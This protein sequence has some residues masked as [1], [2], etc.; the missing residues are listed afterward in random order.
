MEGRPVVGTD[1]PVEGLIVS[2]TSI[3]QLPG[4]ELIL[5]SRSC[6]MIHA[7]RGTCNEFE[8]LSSSDDKGRQGQDVRHIHRLSPLIGSHHETSAPI[9][10]PH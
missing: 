9:C 8:E 7:V 6:T 5:R 1:E 3:E 4:K 2:K 10:S